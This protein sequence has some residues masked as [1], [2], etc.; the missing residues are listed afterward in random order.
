MNEEDLAV[1]ESSPVVDP[2]KLESVL[3]RSYL[4]LVEIFFQFVS[5]LGQSLQEEI[6]G[7]E[8]QHAILGEG[9]G[10]IFAIP[11]PVSLGKVDCFR[12]KVVGIE[13]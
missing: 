7:V 13:R 4:Y 1:D 5:F 6:A 3:D 12:E 2:F 10:H 8:S 11:A 9:I